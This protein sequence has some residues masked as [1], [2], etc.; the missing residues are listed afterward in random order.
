MNFQQNIIKKILIKQNIYQKFMQQYLKEI[1]HLRLAELLDHLY[2]HDTKSSINIIIVAIFLI[3]KLNLLFW[4][5]NFNKEHSDEIYLNI[6]GQLFSWITFQKPL[7]IID[8]NQLKIIISIFYTFLHITMLAVFTFSLYNCQVI[9]KIFTLYISY[10]QL[11]ILYHTE[12]HQLN[13]QYDLVFTIIISLP[14]YINYLIIVYCS[15]NYFIITQQHMLR[16]YSYYNYLILLADFFYFITFSF[17]NSDYV[18]QYSLL[19][20]SVVYFVDA[21]IMQPYC[22][23]FNLYYIGATG[24]FLISVIIRIVLWDKTLYTQFYGIV[25]LVPLFSY[26]FTQ[27]YQIISDDI[28]Q[29]KLSISLILNLGEIINHYNQNS[30]QKGIGDYIIK[31]FLDVQ[32]LN[33]FNIFQL[34]E[35]YIRNND[36]NGNDEELQ[37]YRILLKHEIQGTYLQSLLETKRNLMKN[38]KHSIFFKTIGFLISKKYDQQIKNLYQ[39]E[40]KSS[41]NYHCLIIKIK[42]ADNLFQNNI[43]LFFNLI[44]QK[45]WIWDQLQKGYDNV[46]NCV[47]DIKQ[48]YQILIK[49]KSQLVSIISNEEMESILKLSTLKRFNFVELRFLSLFF[50]FIV[51][52]YQQTKTIEN[53][54]EDLIKQ[55][56]IYSNSILL[57][58]KIMDNDLIII[59]SSILEQTGKIFRANTEEI[60]RFFG[61][62]E[63]IKKRNLGIINLFMPKF[64]SQDHDRFIQKFI[65]K[66]N[67][68]LYNKGKQV[69][70]K[71]YEGFVFPIILSFLHIN[72]KSEDFILTSA[73]QKVQSNQD[74]ILFD[75]NGK[76]LG[77]SKYVYQ[78][79]M[80]NQSLTNNST[81][82]SMS[83]Q[84]DSSIYECY[85]Q[86][87]IPNIISLIENLTLDHEQYQIN[88][89]II[90][91][92]IQTNF[93]QYLSFFKQYQQIN[94]NFCIDISYF[95]EFLKFVDEEIPKNQSLNIKIQ[96]EIQIQ[97]HSLPTDQLYY[98]CSMSKQ[99]KE[100]Q[101]MIS[102]DKTISTQQIQIPFNQASPKFITEIEKINDDLS[103]TRRM[104]EKQILL[105]KDGYH[106][107]REELIF[108]KIES[109]QA[110]NK[111]N[112]SFEKKNIIHEFDDQK[113]SQSSRQSR[114]SN[115]QVQYQIRELQKNQGFCISIKKI[116]IITLFLY[117]IIYLLVF[118]MLMVLSQQL[119]LLQYDIEL[120]RIPDKFNRLY[121]SFVTIG[122]MDLERSLLGRDYGQYLIYRIAHH[123]KSI[124]HEMEHMMI[125][126]KNKFSILENEQRL[127]NLTVRFLNQY[128]YFETQL[129]MIQ[130][131][132]IADSYT[133]QIYQYINQEINYT[134][135]NHYYIIDEYYKLQF[136]K[137]NLANQIS[138][139]QNLIDEI[140]VEI[141]NSQ[142]TTIIILYIL[143]GFQLFFLI[144]GI[145]FL[146]HLWKQPF[147][148]VQLQ[149][150]LLSQLSDSQIKTSIH[151]AK[152]AKQIINHPYIWKR[153]NYLN[154]FYNKAFQRE[155]QD[156]FNNIQ[157]NNLTNKKAKQNIRMI[158]Y[159]FNHFNIYLKNLL[160][161]LLLLSFILSSFFYMKNGLDTSKSEIQLT[162]QYVQFKQDLDSLMI[163]SQLLKTNS[164][165]SERVR[166]LGFLDQNFQLLDPKKYFNILEKELLQK[167]YQ[168]EQKAQNV[169]Q[170]IFQDIIDSKKISNTDKEILQTLYQDDLCSVIADQL[171]FC[172]FNDNQFDDF[173]DY[174]TPRRVD[175]NREIFRNGINGIFQ[176]LIAIFNSY[177]EL[178]LQGKENR[179]ETETQY[180]LQTPEFQHYI[181][182]YFFDVNKAVVQFFSTI[183]ESTMK[184]LQTDFQNSL[185]YYLVFGISVLIVQGILQIYNLSKIQELVS[186][187]KFAFILMPTEC[188]SEIKCLAII[189][190]IV[191]SYDQ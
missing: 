40:Q 51:N 187:C 36:Q 89:I 133:E 166:E 102:F 145:L 17:I 114:N 157:N 120:V 107:K 28:F 15:R 42:E 49:L 140:I 174:P 119:Q 8:S 66:G 76:I 9:S 57:N 160:Y 7:D 184:I 54:I 146:V 148:I 100:V 152:Q 52:D 77:I 44:E 29:Q 177:Y 186:A 19:L 43:N 94:P 13:Y 188:L 179:N 96:F 20:L 165:L 10:F 139:S 26:I 45:I 182:E 103:Q 113:I 38:K 162:L 59:S 176:K 69:F 63:A 21:I 169:N 34:L 173:P 33:A 189:K 109:Q 106:D 58:T 183:L 167:F 151:A 4:T 108:S 53:H 30:I 98:I 142:K 134:K 50:S 122:Q 12:I 137:A 3:Q 83:S 104:L 158:D 154:E 2:F 171:P 141:Q 82:Q 170:I 62:D 126:L 130:F 155:G 71:D 86:F 129:T 118:L 123:G 97:S 23:K 147:G 27:I 11:V 81:T 41:Q 168:K 74:Y 101:S 85:I 115:F 180:F 87:W 144:G 65:N 132:I 191:K 39:G 6:S 127:S 84:V 156:I 47:K 99:Q 68:N 88:K 112:N 143:L 48:L 116:W 138:S 91:V 190:Q 181:L 24:I 125:T 90:E 1:F 80:N 64:I 93:V 73:L 149:I 32:Q 70:C 92:A 35:L 61:Y 178:E 185:F 110:M 172:N 46:E 161:V 79:L 163:V 56:N 60:S 95:E 55:E 25:L 150:Q 67:S 5:Q 16:K 128:S 175:N 164:V 75:L 117:I 121:C 135:S 22:I 131:D 14:P 124:R 159:K 111:V 136:M 105:I 72:E 37:L 78:M 153:T 18:S 31:R